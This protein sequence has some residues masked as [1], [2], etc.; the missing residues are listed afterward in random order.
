MIRDTRTMAFYTEYVT[1]DIPGLLFTINQMHK[2]QPYPTSFRCSVADE[3]DKNRI[4]AAVNE[5]TKCDFAE[6][7]LCVSASVDA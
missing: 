6:S 4:N 2:P 3:D 5:L 7:T 1:P